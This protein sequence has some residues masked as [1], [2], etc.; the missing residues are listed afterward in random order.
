MTAD[1]KSWNSPPQLLTPAVEN[2]QAARVARRRAFRRQFEY[3]HEARGYVPQTYRNQLTPTQQQTVDENAYRDDDGS[4][5]GDD[6][7]ASLLDVIDQHANG[8]RAG[9]HHNSGPF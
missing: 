7:T 8:E 2:T 4:E 5:W 9:D 6:L 1:N 3:A